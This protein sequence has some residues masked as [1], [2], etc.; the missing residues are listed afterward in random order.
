MITSVNNKQIKMVL[1]F[2]EVKPPMCKYSI[3]MNQYKPDNLFNFIYDHTNSPFDP[4]WTI[5]SINLVTIFTEY[6]LVSDQ[7]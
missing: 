5:H 2:G 7:N 1:N 4:S 3:A 6:C